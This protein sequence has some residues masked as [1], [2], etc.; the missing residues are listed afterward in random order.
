MGHRGNS[1][2]E[3]RL[4]QQRLD[5]NVTGAPDSPIFRDI[6][7]IL[8][9]PEEAELARQIPSHPTS[10]N[11]LSSKMGIPVEKLGDKLS[12][13][14]H[15]G[16]VVD[17]QLQQRRYFVLPPVVIGFFEYTFMRTRDNMPMSEL[18][19]LFEE[20]MGQDERF[21]KSVFGGSTQLGRSFVREDA[22]PEG[23]H[24]EILDWERASHVVRESPTVGLS[25]C[26]CRHK[27]NHLGKACERPMENCFSFG[28]AAEFLVRNGLAKPITTSEALRLLEQS[29]ELGL[30]QTG[31]NVQNKVTYLCNCCGCCCE[32]IQ[33]IKTFD[34]RNA[35]VSSN[36]IMDI[37]TSKCK[38]CGQCAEICPVNAIEVVLQDG[39]ETNKR[40]WAAR[41]ETL[42]LGCGVCYS[43]CKSGAISMKPRAQRVFT[44]ETAF[45]RTVSMAIERGKLDELLGEDPESLSPQAIERIIR[46]LEKSPNLQAAIAI[47]PLRSAFLERSCKQSAAHPNNLT[48]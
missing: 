7:K 46:S 29:K 44:P 9:S 31:D 1:A 47:E 34:L 5:R 38:G 3:Y 12:E 32:M 39:K 22:L 14:A 42:C 15:R 30:A 10:L 2:Y 20:Y 21:A 37:D 25:L 8:F 6:L 48:T 35:I 41:E 26:A 33:A 40:R 18:A 11:A 23:D 16:L 45:D 4:L 28:H 19:R 27:A 24:T 43:A 13:M 17:F 36:W